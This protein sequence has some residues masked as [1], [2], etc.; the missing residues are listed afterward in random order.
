MQMRGMGQWQAA[1]ITAVPSIIKMFGGGTNYAN[2]F[3]KQ[4]GIGRKFTQEEANQ[5][6]ALSSQ[7]GIPAQEL[8]KRDAAGLPMVPGSAP[9]TS[10]PAQQPVQTPG[11]FTPTYL[12]LPGIA[13]TQQVP[14]IVYTAPP[15]YH[16]ALQPA[17]Q[18][19]LTLTPTTLAML[20]I[21]AAAIL[22]LRK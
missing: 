5:Y 11:S 8:A 20:G 6:Y 3:S 17:Q 4:V 14:Q 18:A 2:N 9:A 22:L 19:A 10:Q 15:Q 13:P 21:G 12:P 1:A 16:P 7:T